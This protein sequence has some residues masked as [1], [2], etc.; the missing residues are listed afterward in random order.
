M[1][2]LRP[3]AS[4]GAI[5]ETEVQLMPVPGAGKVLSGL[6]MDRTEAD[7]EAG[8]EQALRP[9]GLL[10]ALGEPDGHIGAGRIA[11]LEADWQRAADRLMEAARL[12]VLLPSIRGGTLWEVER[13]L[14]GGLIANTNVIDPPNNEAPGKAGYSHSREWGEPSRRVCRVRFQL[15]AERSRRHALLVRGLGGAHPVKAGLRARFC[16]HPGLCRAG[17]RRRAGRARSQSI[18]RKRAHA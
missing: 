8:V 1:L 4:T 9:A 15:A 12:I 6:V 14:A 11:G 7:F 3:F 16:Q 13:L 10:V 18:E 2:Y 17:S 5:A